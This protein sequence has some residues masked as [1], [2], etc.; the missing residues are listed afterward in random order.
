M[1]TNADTG[2]AAGVSAM[3]LATFEET[4]CVTVFRLA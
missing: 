4:D 2:L 3:L 1:L